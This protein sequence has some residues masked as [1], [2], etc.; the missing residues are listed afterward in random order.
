MQHIE[1]EKEQTNRRKNKRAKEIKKKRKQG[2]GDETKET[3]QER[4]KEKRTIEG[5]KQDEKNRKGAHQ[6]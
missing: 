1:G 3:K 2:M 6:T 4:G 5:S